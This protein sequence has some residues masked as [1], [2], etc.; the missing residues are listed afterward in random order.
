MNRTNSVL[1]F[2]VDSLK[3][4]H[5]GLTLHARICQSLAHSF[6]FEEGANVLCFLPLEED[7][8]LV[9][10]VHGLEHLIAPLPMF[11]PVGIVVVEVRFPLIEIF[12]LG[13][14]Q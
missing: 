6:G 2:L 11:G 7:Y 9:W 10:I 13:L 4:G 14:A 8:Y 1:R 12:Y 5:F 3:G